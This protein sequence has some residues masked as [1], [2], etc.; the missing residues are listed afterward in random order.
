MKDDPQ[1]VPIEKIEIETQQLDLTQAVENIQFVSAFNRE[2]NLSFLY[3]KT[4]AISKTDNF[5]V[6]LVDTQ[7]RDF[8]T[9][10]GFSQ[11]PLKAST[12]VEFQTKI[13]EIKSFQSLNYLNYST[14]EE[15]KL[16]IDNNPAYLQVFEWFYEKENLELAHFFGLVLQHN[17]TVLEINGSCLKEQMTGYLKIFSKITTSVRFIYEQ[18]HF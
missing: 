18:P 11:S 2:L 13:D 1:I 16:F 7:N 3:P 14:I 6:L 17:N 8:R 10:I 15:E 5:A 4:W 12:P 9:N